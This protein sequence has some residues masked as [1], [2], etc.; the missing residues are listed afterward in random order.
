MIEVSEIEGEVA[1]GL[2]RNKGEYLILRRSEKTSSSGKWNFPGGKIEK[3]ES[4]EEA[5]TREIEEETGL[6]PEIVRTAESFETEAELGV[7][8]IHPFLL[9]SD[10]RKLELNYEHSDY[11]WVKI[12][13]L[14]D[15][16]NLGDMKA[17]KVLEIL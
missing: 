7:W 13:E 11:K 10:S 9:K 6:N 16:D 12:E 14:E 1:I 5:V 4:S 2:I 8:K 15:L 17:P 3:N